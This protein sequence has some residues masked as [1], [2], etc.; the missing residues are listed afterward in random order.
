MFDAISRIEDPEMAIVWPRPVEKLDRYARG[1]SRP[2]R[3][4]SAMAA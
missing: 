2:R 1:K 4:Y 3:K